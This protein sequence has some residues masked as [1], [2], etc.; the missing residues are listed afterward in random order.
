[1]KNLLITA[2]IFATLL[3]SSCGGGGGGTSSSPMPGSAS[4]QPSE[5]PV[6]TIGPP[7]ANGTAGVQFW[8]AFD[9]GFVSGT[10]VT[11]FK[12]TIVSGTLPTGLQAQVDS[13]SSEFFDISG[14]EPTPGSFKLTLEVRDS[15]PTPR[16]IARNEITLNFDAQFK[17]VK[18]NLDLKPTV[19]NRAYS[20]FIP[21]ANGTPPITWRINPGS[22]LDPGLQ[23]NA[24]TGEVSGTP[25][26]TFG[27]FTAVATDSSNPVKAAMQNYRV[28]INPGLQFNDQVAYMSPN[29]VSFA[30]LTVS[31]GV[32][33]Y[34]LR[35]V[36]GSL[37]PGAFL[38]GTM[39]TGTATARGNFSA[40]LE[41]ADAMVPPNTQ[42]ANV[43]VTVESR[44]VLAATKEL[45]HGI[46]GVPYSAQ[47]TAAY[48]VAPYSWALAG[49]PL[50]A[51]LTL[52]SDGSITGTPTTPG[53]QTTRFGVT[54]SSYVPATSYSQSID[55]TVRPA[56]AGR[57]DT[58]ATATSLSNV[59]SLKLSLSPYATANGVAQ[60]DQDYFKVTANGG[61]TI[62]VIVT[63]VD[64]R[65]PLDPAIEILASD[66]SRPNTCR[67]QGT[68]DGLTP[69]T[70]DP[71]PNAFDDPCVN[72][73]IDP[74][75]N[76]DSSLDMQV[77]GVGPQVLYI[78]VFDLN[79]NAR[80][81]MEYYLQII[82]V[83]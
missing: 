44:N 56:A 14:I 49:N 15:S 41:A 52:A 75:V 69:G 1:M 2:T 63:R 29:S 78:H 27:L 36:S 19:A 67:N 33:P 9:I 58:L 22:M 60:P 46:V 66:G 11:P 48:G 18:T 47:L 25:T 59:N 54:D 5:T 81:D 38:Q 24:S 8:Q 83:N 53:T 16:L 76:Q 77:P 10:K 34:T 51:G 37:P 72:D 45:P 17:F 79:G 71:T 13:F 57:N 32:S 68:T 50:P 80:P 70:V 31:G 40:I 23:L 65:S 30:N 74:G 6:T 28:P 39:I 42:Q 12:W 73:D 7:V 3:I 62:Q 43:H 64:T 21:V 20:D 55:V 4:T 26:T 61:A 82:G 35:F